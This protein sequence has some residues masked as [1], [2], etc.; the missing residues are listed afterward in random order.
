MRSVEKP[1][2]WLKSL[3]I[4]T[5]FHSLESV[6]GISRKTLSGL[7]MNG[8]TDRAKQVRSTTLSALAKKKWL[9]GI[10]CFITIKQEAQMTIS[11]AYDRYISE[12][13]Q[14]KGVDKNQVFHHRA[15]L[16]YWLEI[17]GDKDISEIDLED[18][19]LFQSKLKTHEQHRCNNTIHNYICD[20]RMMLKYWK[21]RG[22]DCL[23]FNLIPAPKKDAVVP[24]F[25]SAEEVQQIIDA[26]DIIRT[27]FIISLLFSSGIRVSELVQLN[28]DSI[29]DG[30]F[31]VIGKG[32]KPRICFT[33]AR[34][35]YYMKQYLEAR[36]DRSDA[37]ILTKDGTRASVSTIQLIIRNATDKAR[38]HKHVSPHTFRHSFATNYIENGGNIRHL[39]DLLGHASLNTTA[40]YTHIVNNDL[41][42]EYRK[43]HTV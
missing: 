9:R 37:L 28:R 1:T 17:I 39:A 36:K 7:S 14:I 31:T 6:S 15:C 33:D 10:R 19:A 18:V 11:E 2:T 13:L 20:I 24:A 8:H 34:T 43:F 26:T 16:R 3:E 23:D 29:K 42:R 12:Y 30:V 25:L 4:T 27:K 5:T 32:R 35:N 38:I 22:E 21:L 41:Y 40:H